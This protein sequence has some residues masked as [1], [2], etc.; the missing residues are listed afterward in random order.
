MLNFKQ[1]RGIFNLTV[2]CGKFFGVSEEFLYFAWYRISE[3]KS[4]PTD[5]IKVFIVIDKL[6]LSYNAVRQK[7]EL[8]GEISTAKVAESFMVLSGSPFNYYHFI[9]SLSTC[10]CVRFSANDSLYILFFIFR[11]NRRIC[12]YNFDS[13][14][15]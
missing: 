10:R 13:S 7:S 4:K 3:R 1:I 2:F 11:N 5:W 9:Y 8:G 12:F 14:M 6:Y 15:H